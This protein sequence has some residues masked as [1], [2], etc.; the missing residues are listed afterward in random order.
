MFINSISASKSDVIDQ[1]L[2]K[3]Y[4][5]YVLRYPGFGSKNE[6]ALNFGS[7]IHK[8][9]EEGYKLKDFKSLLKVAEAERP[10]YRVPFRENDRMKACLENFLSWNQKLGETVA[11]EGAYKIPLDV[12]RD[13]EFIGII[14]R[15]I[16]GTD[17]SYLVIDYKTSKREKKKKDLLNDKQLMGYA[18]AIH[19]TYNI[20]YDKIYCSHYYPLSNNFVSVRFSKFQI[21]Q[22]EK[23][24]IDKVW[25]IRKKKKDEF[26]SQRN[27][28]CDW[29][30]YQPACDKFNCSSEV[31]LRMD[32]Q[33]KLKVIKD[34]ERKA[35]KL[36]EDD[37]IEKPKKN[38]PTH[39]DPKGV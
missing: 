7:F 29:C 15:V 3:Y 19:R 20:P 38:E 4:L 36:L 33:K 28:F 10:T 5:R 25:K 6:D 8:V 21:F 31:A 27:V 16:K 1:C 35:K 24:E 26:Y 14:D 2:W 30:E 34:A 39:K 9:F 11:T 18:F 17:G 23:K 22:W 37:R 32:E 12:E 13:I